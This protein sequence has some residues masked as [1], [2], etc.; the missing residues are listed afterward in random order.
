VE[1]VACYVGG[2]WREA[3]SGAVS[4]VVDPATGETIAAVPACSATDIT[5]AVAAAARARGHWAGTTP[6]ERAECLLELA[7]ALHSARDEFARIESANTGKPIG[8]A[9]GEIASAVDR[10]RFF[11]GAARC[12]E[13][14]AAGEYTP[15]YTSMTRR[16]PLGVAGL[17]TP[18]NYPLLLAVTKL[19]PALA[20]GN[21]VVLK[22]SEHTPLTALRLAALSEAILPAGVFNVVTGDGATAGA[23]LAAHP[24]VDVV[25]LTGGPDTGREVCR[26]AASTLKRV[27]T[28][29]GGKAPCLVLDD[30]DPAQVAAAVR[31]GAFWNAGQDC[32]AAS[33]VIVTSGAYDAVVS[34]LLPA[35]ASLR[36]GG[37]T[38]P[39]V[40]MGPLVYAGHRDRVMGFIERAEQEGAEILAG[41]ARCDRPGFF[42]APTVVTDVEQ[43]SEIVQ[44]EVFGPVV[45]VQRAADG[46]TA[47]RY[48]G[49][50]RYGLAAS[51]FTR[52]VARAMDAARR[53]RFGT[54]WVNDHGPVTPEM[55][56]GGFKES[57]TGTERSVYSL[58]GFTQFKHVMIRLPG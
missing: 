15:G 53:L 4:A 58:E 32:S 13:G 23:A 57:G 31:A 18:W 9:R 37:P 49:D 34:E 26:A 38:D 29:L 35:V 50:V 21:T 40:E 16:E 6:A 19:A 47:F 54:V 25:S 36:V 46:E 17:I 12:L 43:R 56:W 8:A 48:A 22:P 3:G 1:R 27:H 55:P 20:A 10:L 52:D 45:T 2:E 14:R 5:A 33:R 30:A 39:G 42:V 51:V 11:A 7:A 41:G 28:E 44:R 24:D